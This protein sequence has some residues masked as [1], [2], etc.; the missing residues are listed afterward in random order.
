MENDTSRASISIASDS[1]VSSILNQ[2]QIMEN[3]D[4]DAAYPNPLHAS[5]T[6]QLSLNN[7]NR[8]QSRA[9]NKSA[10]NAS[11][12][13]NRPS[14][15]SLSPVARKISLPPAIPQPSPI[16]RN[17]T[18]PARLRTPPP[19]P[20]SPAQTSQSPVFQLNSTSQQEQRSYFQN[21]DSVVQR[22]AVEQVISLMARSSSPN[23]A[24]DNDDSR[25][26]HQNDLKNESFGQDYSQQDQYY[27]EE[28]NLSY[29]YA[30]LAPDT[31]PPPL[32]SSTESQERSYGVN[33]GQARDFGD[34]YVN[35][36]F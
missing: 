6:S 11:L 8:S 23:I 5:S 28:K 32:P 13:P 30:P 33:E 25:N 16:S 21:D 29:V 17:A 15:S 3:G 22:E 34:E 12:A 2:S 9:S 19:L 31:I 18:V 14:I 1:D 36:S 26:T 10:S 20:P 7:L 24:F 4:S 27:H 35:E